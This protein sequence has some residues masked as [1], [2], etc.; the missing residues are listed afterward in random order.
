[1]FTVQT[2]HDKNGNIVSASFGYGCAEHATKADIREFTGKSSL[3]RLARIFLRESFNRVPEPVRLS[4]GL[5][6]S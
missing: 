1:M 5:A 2:S 4:M 6:T 3:P